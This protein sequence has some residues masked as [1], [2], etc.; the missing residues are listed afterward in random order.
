MRVD[1]SRMT[2]EFRRSL[3]ESC[4]LV[5]LGD[6]EHSDAVLSAWGA[7]Q[8]V[9]GGAVT[10]V[11]TIGSEHSDVAAEVDDRWRELAVRHSV[12]DADGEF[13]ISVAGEG[14]AELGWAR[15][16]ASDRLEM[17]RRLTSQSG[18]FSPEFVTADVAGRVV[19]GVTDEED[20]VWLVLR[21]VGGGQSSCPV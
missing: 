7:W 15:V 1:L 5:V 16:R 17:A 21:R 19:L 2:R 9:I 4:G 18:C 3:L 14:A 6:H 20:G 8:L 13:L 10:P 12:I 11:L